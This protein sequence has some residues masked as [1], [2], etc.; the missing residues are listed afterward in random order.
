MTRHGIAPI[1]AD[2]KARYRRPAVRHAEPGRLLGALGDKVDEQVGG[3]DGATDVTD[4]VQVYRTVAVA[5]SVGKGVEVYHGGVSRSWTA[6]SGGRFGSGDQHGA[7]EGVTGHGE[8]ED[9]R[10]GVGRN[11]CAGDVEGVHHDEVAVLAVSGWRGGADVVGYAR[12]VGQLVG[13]LWQL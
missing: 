3:A 9:G 4:G 10:C 13:A 7:S 6:L 1:A 12:I 5:G 8:A 11:A 2:R